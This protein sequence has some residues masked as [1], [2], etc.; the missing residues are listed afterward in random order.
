MR[1]DAPINGVLIGTLVAVECG[2]GAWV[3][4]ESQPGTAA[5]RARTTVELHGAHIGCSVALMFERG[6]S[7][8]PIVMGVMQDDLAAANPDLQLELDTDGTR[9]VITAR[10]RLVLSCGKARIT[11]TRSGK[12]LIEGT[13]LL[14][15]SSGTNRIKGGSVQLN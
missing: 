7:S 13:Y 3:C 11:L 14:S 9:S 2:G 10:D 5:V 4:F 12:V 1:D 15:R 8:K 6:D